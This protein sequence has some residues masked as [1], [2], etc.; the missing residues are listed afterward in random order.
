MSP[1]ETPLG[2]QQTGP[3]HQPEH[4]TAFKFLNFIFDGI[5]GGYAEFR[6]FAAGRK[7]KATGPPCYLEIPLDG[8][9]V[10]EE[11][12][13]R[14]GQ[15]S[16]MFGPAPRYRVPLRGR[17]G[18]EG[19]VLQAGCVWVNLDYNRAAGGAIEII[20]R[21]RRFPL[22]PSVAVNSGYGHHLYF[23]FNSPLGAGRLTEWLYMMRGLG[24]ALQVAE[25]TRLSQVMRLP[26]TFNFKENHPVP[27][28]VWEEHS[29]WARYHPA[30]VCEAIQE[31]RVLNRRK[32]M[33]DSKTYRRSDSP[34]VLPLDFLRERGV[35]PYLLEAVVTGRMPT[36]TE[37]TADDCEAGSGRDFRIASKLFAHGL[38]A[39]EV[40]ASFRAHPNGCGSGWARKKDGEK[41]LNNL[42]SNVVDRFSDW[43]HVSAADGNLA[44]DEDLF[45]GRLPP[46]YTRADDGSIWFSPP[47]ADTA[48]KAAKP[49]KVGDSVIRIGEIRENVDTGQISL[50]LTFDYLGRTRSAL[51]SRSQMSSPRQLV[52][53][54]AGLGAPVTS[55]NARL[56]LAYLAAYE[57]AFA[58]TIPQKKTTSRFGSG[59]TGGPFFLPGLL[60]S[61]EF[62]P[63]GA[64]DASLYRAYASRNGSLRGWVD[65]MRALADE[66]LMIP[67][68]VVLAALVPPLQRRLQIPNFIVDIYGNTSTG[69]STSLKL[70]ASVYGRPHDP[71]SIVQQWMNTQTAIEQVAGMCG[72]LPIF[73]DD[74]QHCT[75]ELKRSAVYMIANGRGKGRGGGAGGVLETPTWH[76]VALSTSEEPLHESSPHEGARGRILPV[77]GLVPPFRPGTAAL[78]QVLE[79]AVTLNHGHAGEA[80]VRH[81]NGWSAMEW[82]RWRE[83]YFTLRA[84]LLKNT[85]SNVIGRVCGYVAAIQVA[86]E[87]A[88]PLLGLPFQPDVVAAWLMLH[89]NEQEGDR[90]VVLAA[91]RVLADHYLA[92]KENFSGEGGN[93]GSRRRPLQGMARR[94]H[95]VGFLRNTIDVAFRSR[96]WNTTAL[97]N[98]MAAAGVLLTTEHDRFTKKVCCEGVKHRMVCIKWAALLPEDSHPSGHES[99]RVDSG[100]SLAPATSPGVIGAAGQE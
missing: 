69:K 46:G 26:G 1:T 96:K 54:L 8:G 21:I 20:E 99:E 71:D 85:S 90:N 73:L 63:L 28:E 29:S 79:K 42:L 36:L 6:Y 86:A 24:D 19:D 16:V 50:L 98:K 30:E 70:A 57:H 31:G 23:A 22:R 67:Q 10:G 48:G 100:Y 92:N 7:P 35:A 89:I 12:L 32:Q 2:G 93:V 87:V 44:G 56:T 83:R 37:G 33:N 55:N 27:C 15:Q 60:S 65:A 66:T 25:G 72:E 77:G 88:C 53:T 68:A 43:E 91:L 39:D 13:G 58:A 95:Y 76:T 64:G 62:S 52:S 81:L 11:M 18:K 34:A 74:A 94:P 47:V 5:T 82:L 14:A 49:V 61:V 38:S 40:K 3:A 51:V 41:Y 4:D 45:G 84:E 59:R 97:L 78:V 9:R 80:Y 75:A 17:R